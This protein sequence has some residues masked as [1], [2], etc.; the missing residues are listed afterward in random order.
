MPV[1]RAFLKPASMEH[2]APQGDFQYL[3][4]IRLYEASTAAQLEADMNAQFGGQS[5]DDTAYFVIESIQ[6]Q[7]AVTRLHN[8]QPDVRYSALVHATSMVKV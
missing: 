7:V 2:A 6:Y 3:P 5:A 4:V 8:N 1:T